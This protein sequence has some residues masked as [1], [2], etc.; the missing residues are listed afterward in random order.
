MKKGRLL[1]AALSLCA[2]VTAGC[3]TASDNTAQPSASAAANQGQGEDGGGETAPK[4]LRYS[5]GAE[6]GTLDSNKSTDEM[7]NEVLFHIGEGLVRNYDNETVPG[8]AEKWDLSEDGLTYT[9]HLRESL[10]SDGVPLTAHDF[11]Y[12]F[13]RFLD[14]ATGASFTETLDPV[15]NATAYNKGEITDPSQVGVTAL[16]DHTLEI[17]LTRP[18]S[19]FLV[20]LGSNSYFYPV[21]QDVVEQYGPDYASDETKLVTNGPFKLEKW[22]HEAEIRMVKNENYWDKDN[23]KLDGITQLIVPDS[24]TA[25]SM[26][27]TGEL[28]YLGDIPAA[29]ISGY[30]DATGSLSGSI[31][32]LQF[33]VEGMTPE[34]GKVIANTN[35]RKA[36]SYAISR[37]DIAAAVAP[38]GTEPASRFILPTFSSFVAD[39]P[40]EG[41]PVEGDAEA[42]K[43]YLDKALEELGMTADQLPKIQYVGM[44][45]KNKVYAEALQDAWLQVLGLSNIDIQIL[46]VPQAIEATMNRQYDIY[47][48]GL[49]AS[50]DT[51][52]ILGY[53]LAGGSI[54]WT[55]WNDEAY[56]DMYLAAA[57]LVDPK[58]QEAAIAETEQYL[59]EHGPLEPFLYPGISYVAH[60]YVTGIVKGSVGASSQLIYAD[61]RK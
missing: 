57:E 36:L 20:T 24:N 52:E 58:E 14:P 16:D 15:V 28:D 13:K 23:I 2:M 50:R 17:K 32:M 41:V 40:F 48:Q 42:A 46:P 47:V 27:D 21:R 33:N 37:K 1:F 39:H 3:T 31:Q 35:F 10:W 26:Y 9:F 6:P 59:F 56:T 19:Y 61:I 5:R 49:S 53:W 38:P 25:A 12:T 45:G 44:E 18:V 7:S 11:E 29:L 51:S 22:A 34:S 43:A 30:P 60:D 54:N 8:I 4:V 55:G